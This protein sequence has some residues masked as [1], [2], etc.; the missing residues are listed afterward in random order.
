MNWPTLGRADSTLF[1]SELRGGGAQRDSL[2]QRKKTERP[3]VKLADVLPIPL[4][5]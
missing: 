5:V 3:A 4:P 2:A 1:L